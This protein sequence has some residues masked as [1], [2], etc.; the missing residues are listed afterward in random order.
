MIELVEFAEDSTSTS[1]S[2]DSDSNQDSDDQNTTTESLQQDTQPEESQQDQQNETQQEKGEAQVIQQEQHL[3]EHPNEP[4][5]ELAVEEPH[6]EQVLPHTPPE[7]S[8]LLHPVPTDDQD[9]P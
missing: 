7:P 5:Q 1:Q 3:A 6:T 9:K 4:Q 8:P 2:S